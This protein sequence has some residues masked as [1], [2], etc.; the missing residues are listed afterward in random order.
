MFALPVAMSNC[1]Y[2]SQISVFILLAANP[3]VSGS[4]PLISIISDIISDLR[5]VTRKGITRYLL[6]DD[7]I[8]ELYA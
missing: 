8:M 2:I 6:Q 4:N 7:N 5:F 3:E 1:W